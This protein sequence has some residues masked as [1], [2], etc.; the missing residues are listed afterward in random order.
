MNKLGLAVLATVLGVGLTTFM[1]WNFKYQLY[2]YLPATSSLELSNLNGVLLDKNGKAFTGR[3]KTVTDSGY[4]LYAYKDGQLDGLN[5]VF[6]NGKLREIGHWEKGLQNGLF[7]SWTQEGILIDHG[8]FKDG[9]RDGETIQYWA[10]SGKLKIKANY[11]NGK[12]NGLVE[13][14]YP[15]GKLQFKHQYVNQLL[16]GEALDYYENGQLRSSVTFE[17]SKQTG[18]YKLFS[19]QGILL[20]EGVLKSGMRHGPF[21]IYSAQTGQPVRQGTY[22]MNEYDGEITVWHPNGMKVVQTFENGVPHGW[23]RTFNS[24]GALMGEMM[25]KNGQATGE[26]RSYDSRG[27]VIQEG[28]HNDNKLVNLQESSSPRPHPQEKPSD[29]DGIVIKETE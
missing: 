7:E 25:L 26:F 11:R 8:L 5:V 13:Q 1:A 3:V 10:D 18:P 16:D 28:T 2:G 29:R 6:S 12:L 14:Y 19:E 9:Q 4:S 22:N 23:Q 27:N 20:E 17:K 21:V 24:Q 15:S